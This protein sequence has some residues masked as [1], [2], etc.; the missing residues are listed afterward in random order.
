M[1]GI[2]M[3]IPEGWI[4][5]Y[6]HLRGRES[7]HHTSPLPYYSFPHILLLFKGKVIIHAVQIFIKNPTLY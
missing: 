5:W 6:L 1:F 2:T 3:L 4:I 7:V